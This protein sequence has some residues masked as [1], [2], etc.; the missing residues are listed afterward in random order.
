MVMFGGGND[1][2]NND[3]NRPWLHRLDYQAINANAQRNAQNIPRR[4]GNEAR[5]LRAVIRGIN[6]LGVDFNSLK[7]NIE[8]GIKQLINLD[9]GNCTRYQ[10]QQSAKY[11]TPL[12][13]IAYLMMDNGDPICDQLSAIIR[14]CKIIKRG[15]KTR[16]GS[17][18]L[19]TRDYKEA[20]GILL[21]AR[22][23]RQGILR[24]KANLFAFNLSLYHAMNK[25]DMFNQGVKKIMA[26]DQRI[27]DCCI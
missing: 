16:D 3:N 23:I 10:I 8:N 6:Q 5:S 21:A 15:L 7:M 22:G 14:N 2:D 18:Y 9:N 24:V 27:N 25:H 19:N 17:N 13:N 11:L 1:G 12:A 20:Q 26:Q 4:I